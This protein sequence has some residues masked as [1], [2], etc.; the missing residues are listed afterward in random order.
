MRKRSGG[1]KEVIRG[2][3]VS[4][5]LTEEEFLRL[6]ANALRDRTSVSRM[7]RD[8]LADLIDGAPARAMQ[9]EAVAAA[10]VPA[11]VEA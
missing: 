2:R 3:I 6:K 7:A 8:R 1:Y 11:A 10:E 5:R 4:M 9:A